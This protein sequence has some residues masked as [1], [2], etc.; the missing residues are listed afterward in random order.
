MDEYTPLDLKTFHNAG[1]AL[2]AEQGTAPIGPQQFRGLPFLIGTD[3]QT[4][5]SPLE[6]GCSALP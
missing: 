6:T 2:L 4:V 3:P 1:L 5:L